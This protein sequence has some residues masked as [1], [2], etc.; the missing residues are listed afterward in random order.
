MHVCE[1]KY[2]YVYECM[3]MYVSVSAYECDECMYVCF[4]RFKGQELDMNYA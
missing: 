4:I 1:C 3:C 2:V